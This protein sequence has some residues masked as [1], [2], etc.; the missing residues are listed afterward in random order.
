M[1][2]RFEHATDDALELYSLGM[3]AEAETGVLEEHLLIC[4]ECQHR[5][6]E[7]DSYVRHMRAAAAKLRSRESTRRTWGAGWLSIHSMLP[8]LGWVAVALLGLLALA[9]AFVGRMRSLGDDL[10]PVA[11]TLRTSRGQPEPLAAVAPRGRA[12][13]LE[14]DVAGLI[15]HGP[16][17]LEIVDANGRPV[18]R[19]PVRTEGDQLTATMTGVGAGAYWVRL[20]ACGSPPE[21]LREYA[22]H[23]E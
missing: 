15:P 14:A 22:L 2:D 5:L 8:R 21:L 11:V 13:I 6:S 19:R 9:W 17:E 10:P 23:V 16:C 7:T 18:R 3:L 1:Q 4:A 12:L 20:Y